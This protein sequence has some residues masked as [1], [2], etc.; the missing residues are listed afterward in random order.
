[1]YA[2]D[3]GLLF[4]VQTLNGMYAKVLPTTP[5]YDRQL[6]GEHRPPRNVIFGS[7]NDSSWPVT[8]I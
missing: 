4:A 1:M 6:T 7:A 8:A 2:R 3:E 5:P